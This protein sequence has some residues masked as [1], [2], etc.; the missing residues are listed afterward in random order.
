MSLARAISRGRALKARLAVNG[1]KKASR[2]LGTVAAE[3]DEE[4]ACDI[5]WSFRKWELRIAAKLA[6]FAAA[7]NRPKRR[8][9]QHPR[10]LSRNVTEVVDNQLKVVLN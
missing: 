3:T 2:S 9:Y 1:M 5:A 6:R 8:G 4:R 10:R 7:G